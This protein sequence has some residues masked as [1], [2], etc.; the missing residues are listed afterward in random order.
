MNSRSKAF[1][2]SLLALVLLAGPV[3]WQGRNLE[4]Q[5]NSE[6]RTR[7]RHTLELHAAAVQR[8]LDRLDGKLAALEKFVLRETASS[9]VVDLDK[10]GALGA[11]L[12]ASAS[13]IRAFQIVSDGIITHV[14]PLH[15]NE[16]AL[17][18]N[19]LTDER[20]VVGGDVIRALETGRVTI[21]GP[22]PL[23]QGG[24]GIILRKPL[25]KTNAGP[26][27]L[28][29]IVFNIEP[30]LAASGIHSAVTDE[31]QLALRRENGDV[32][33]GEPAVFAQQPIMHRLALPDGAWEIVAKPLGSRASGARN[34]VVIFYLTGST[35]VF[36]ICLL[37]F[38]LARRQAELAETVQART[39]DLQEELVARKRAQEEL[40]QN[41]SLL[42]AVTEG[43]SDAIFVK[44]REGR[45]QMINT[46]GARFFNQTP[47][48]IIGQKDEALVD[49]ETARVFTASDQQAMASGEVQTF[50][51]RARLKNDTVIYH[52]IKSPW[53]DER[54]NIIGVVGISRNITARKRAEEKLQR[55][56]ASLT[57]AQRIAKI[58]NWDLEIPSNQLYWSDQIYEIFGLTKS[59]FGANY[60]A[61]LARVH[62]DDRERVNLAQAAALAGTAPLDIEHRIVLPDGRIKH[63]HELADVIRDAAGR[64]V[65]L[66][67]T[68]HDITTRKQALAALEASE[69]E[70][71][72]LAQ[73][74]E[75]ERARL[76]AAQAVAKVGSWE[77][78]LLTGEVIW[79]QETYRIFGTDPE[80][81]LP[82]HQ[83][84]LNSVHP[85]D[86]EKVD[87][88]FIHSL[89]QPF[90][91]VIEHRIVL[92]N[93]E[94]KP[95][96]ERW[97]VFQDEQGKPIRAIGTCQDLS[98]HK[99]FEKQLRAL[100]ARLQSLR[101]EERIRISR[102][103]HDELGQQL[104]ALKM[105]L[106]WLEGRLEQISDVKL[107]A[108]LEDKIMG[109]S[110]AADE[111][112]ATVQR[113]AAELRPAMLDNLGL[114][115]TLRH[116]AKQFESR[117]GIP[118]ELQLP[119]GPVPLSNEIAT[120]A[121]RIFQEVL[122]NVARHAQATQVQ[123][124]LE[125]DDR[126]L[127]LRVS[128]NGVGVSPE[129]LANPKSLGLLGMTERAAMLNGSVR[130]TGVP[131]KGTCVELE[132]P[133]ANS[134]ATDKRS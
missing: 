107:R 124:T 112:M 74:L 104:T 106:Y 69:R 60:Q 27:R 13:W 37:V 31:V 113:I 126:R 121:Y 85:D 61:F 25:P 92:P 6:E 55:S 4:T 16:A 2:W 103:I 12:H 21:T 24:M 22:L 67:G 98:E 64:A 41:L 26:A 131:G 59:E 3:I 75:S 77:T 117:A 111:T 76:V 122:T 38:L 44:D 72:R 81:F 86:R 5:L 90:P 87:Q 39:R 97:Q 36:L 108:A 66:T 125:V 91:C 96:E 33:F 35:I 130:I 134:P 30:L 9:N 83:A 8:S 58:G 116:E 43:S 53:R 46:A 45:Y 100:S 20:P 52:A 94:V 48:T 93:G 57:N 42:R 101:E 133:I 18:Y 80:H 11:G 7:T 88:A 56:E 115:S 132:I 15:S 118:V 10:F 102:E 19:L 89:S 123:A 120:T 114:I 78:D 54:G 129:N 40:R 1:L 95:A 128:D 73:Q 28:V 32:F 71:R 70:Q 68:V 17:G 50:E 51:D 63:V 79:S 82:T 62:P 99:R 65:R 109:A 110:T 29:A 23:V 34:P 105:D 127:R 14:Y 119:A 84:F 49:L 47:E